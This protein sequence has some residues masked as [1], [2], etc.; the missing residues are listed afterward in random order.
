[1]I[2]K[3]ESLN[4]LQFAATMDIKADYISSLANQIKLEEN[5]SAQFYKALEIFFFRNK[6]FVPSWKLRNCL[7]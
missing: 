7:S 4:S 1:M 5:F 6:L 2:V 3:F